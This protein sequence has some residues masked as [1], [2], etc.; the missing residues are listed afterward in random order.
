MSDYIAQRFE[1]FGPE[2]VDYLQ[3]N[4]RTQP[5]VL[6]ILQRLH[7]E[8][9]AS[10]EHG[11]DALYEFFER[12]GTLI[13]K[14]K[15]GLLKQAEPTVAS[16][17]AGA[18]RPSP[19]DTASRRRASLPESRTA[20]S[21][22]PGRGVSDLPEV[23]RGYPRAV[24]TQEALA[25]ANAGQSPFGPPPLI[26][27]RSGRDRRC[28]IDRRDALEVVFRNHRYGGE[29]RS[30]K[31]RRRNPPPLRDP[32]APVESAVGSEALRAAGWK[33]GGGK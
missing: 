30:G 4:A 12:H 21:S 2:I 27:R 10:P 20:S 22:G 7:L 33:A 6:R 24:I 11:I 13:F 31:E 3:R 14:A 29:R 32:T 18:A 5:A 26:E 19:S 23:L 25:A 9:P 1:K 8:L 28:G 15:M 17:A 16:S